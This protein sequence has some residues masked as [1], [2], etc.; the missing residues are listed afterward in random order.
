M[1]LVKEIAQGNSFSETSE[2]G[3]G[4]FSA[5]RA[6][7]VVLTTPG[8]T[9]N[10]NELTGV[11]IGDPYSEQNPIPCVSLEGR[12][13][14]DSRLV[15]IITATYR[16]TP[17]SV[18]QGGGGTDPKTQE[19]TVRP[20]LYSMSVALSEIAAWGGQR[21]KNGA[22]V[23]SAATNPAGDLVDGVSRLEPVVTINI[24]QYSQTDQS[25][26]LGYVGYV[27]SDAISFS[28]LSIGVHCCM[29]QG[30]SVN[31]VVEQFGSRTFRGFKITF[32][33]GVRTH[34]TYTR[35][36][37]MAIGWGI[38]IPQT[39]FN[40]IN[41]GLGRADVDQQA[42]HLQHD[43]GFVIDP[44]AIVGRTVGQRVRAMVAVPASENKQWVQRVAAQPVALND[45]GT[46][47]ASTA[48]PPV[49]VNRICTQ[50]SMSFG[51][52]FSAF[53]INSIG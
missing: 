51:N 4:A 2:D 46:P 13:D 47:R 35:D 7:K 19:P 20:P 1:A 34:Y 12:A 16:A 52:G 49:Y 29:F 39:G 25:S 8:E 50:P 5:T 40:C 6:W 23:W 10:I 45:D 48:S 11:N 24:D 44:P 3:R 42:I 9:W 15:K 53:G 41:N 43:N 17:G 28:Q 22:W 21:Y 30:L 37:N 32:T 18:V 14:G 27:N 31:P 36:G 26:L 38:A 33:F